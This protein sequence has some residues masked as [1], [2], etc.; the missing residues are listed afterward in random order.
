MNLRRLMEAIFDPLLERIMGPEQRALFR[1]TV[2]GYELVKR[3]IA[4]EGIECEFR[5]RGFLDLAW[6]PSHAIVLQASETGSY[7]PPVWRKP[8]PSP[9][10]TTITLPVHTAVWN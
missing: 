8:L 3:L 7:R 5:E 1:E 4:D 6:A 2:D 10:Q 9:P